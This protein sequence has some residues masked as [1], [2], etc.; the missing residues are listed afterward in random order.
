M[1]S[2][3]SDPV[4]EPLSIHLDLPDTLNVE[5]SLRAETLL[6]CVQEII[7]NTTR[8]AHARNLWIRLEAQPDGI[9]LHA[10]DDG[11]GADALQYGNGLTGMRERFEQH[12]GRIEVSAGRGTGFEIR[13][14]LP[15]AAA[16]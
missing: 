5:E 1:A 7:T 11:R 9:A 8:H 15:R 6:R 13:G 10:H 4:D 12:A 2:E 16:A 3:P 14:F